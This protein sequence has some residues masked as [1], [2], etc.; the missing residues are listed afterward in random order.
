MV[1]YTGEYPGEP[2]GCGNTWLICTLNERTLPEH[3][4]NAAKRPTLCIL[5]VLK[6]ATRQL[7]TSTRIFTRIFRRCLVTA[8]DWYELQSTTP[9]TKKTNKHISDILTQF[10]TFSQLVTF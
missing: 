6:K 4:F 3:P 10:A 9:K 1:G 2:P 8:V 5:L 7:P